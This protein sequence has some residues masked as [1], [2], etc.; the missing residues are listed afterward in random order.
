L[1][2]YRPTDTNRLD[3]NPRSERK[4]D[5]PSVE[6]NETFSVDAVNTSNKLVAHFI[7]KSLETSLVSSK[8][9]NLMHID[10]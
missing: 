6:K 4:Y 3:R 2:T 8:N 10:E 1:N 9:P 7:R 5:T